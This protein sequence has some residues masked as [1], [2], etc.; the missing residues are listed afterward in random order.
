MIGGWSAI[1]VS[2]WKVCAT[3]NRDAPVRGI[4]RDYMGT[5]YQD[6]SRLWA[7]VGE[8]CLHGAQGVRFPSLLLLRQF[9][10]KNSQFIIQRR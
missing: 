1:R 3:T 5:H 2:V 9:T 10:I 4:G 8:L 6:G 7:I